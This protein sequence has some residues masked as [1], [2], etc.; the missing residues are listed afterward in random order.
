M[1]FIQTGWGRCQFHIKR[2]RTLVKCGI[3]KAMSPA[4]VRHAD[5]GSGPL[6]NT[7][8][9][10]K[11]PQLV[12]SQTGATSMLEGKLFWSEIAQ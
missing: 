1:T 6:R 12:Q 7:D 4:Q 11:P 2:R 10:V 9:L 5:S 3:G 8:D